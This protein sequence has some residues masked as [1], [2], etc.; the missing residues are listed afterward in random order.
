MLVPRDVRR[1][2]AALQHVVQPVR[3]AQAVALVPVQPPA[4]EHRVVAHH[5]LPRG[6]RGLQRRIQLGDDVA[7]VVLCPRMTGLHAPLH[8]ARVDHKNLHQL[9][10]CQADGQVVIVVD[11]APQPARVGR[12]MG[13]LN[14]RARVEAVVVVPQTYKP[15]AVQRGL[16]QPHV[17]PHG[18]E[19]RVVLAGHARGVEV[20][21]TRQYKVERLTVLEL[22]L[23]GS[24]D[25]R[26]AHVAIAKVPKGHKTQ[27]VFQ[28]RVLLEPI[29]RQHVWGEGRRQ[30]R[31]QFPFILGH[32]FQHTLQSAAVVPRSHPVKTIPDLLLQ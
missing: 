21:P 5:D 26:S 27:S 24:R 32:H 23:D 9:A 2:A 29:L 22:S 14:L 3:L 31:G 4:R 15:R 8:A 13:E 10:A 7:Q 6:R 19:E 12:V 11:H 30:P 18:L 28:H 1:H 25:I 20:V 17:P 16:L